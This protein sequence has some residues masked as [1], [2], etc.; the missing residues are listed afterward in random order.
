MRGVVTAA[1]A[2]AQGEEQPRLPLLSGV[3]AGGVPTGALIRPGPAL[4]RTAGQLLAARCQAAG[5]C[6]RPVPARAGPGRSAAPRPTPVLRP[7][8]R[9]ARPAVPV[10][11]PWAGCVDAGAP[12]APRPELWRPVLAVGREGQC[13]GRVGALAQPPFPVRTR[14]GRAGRLVCCPLRW[15]LRGPEAQP[16][17]A[18]ARR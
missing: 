15:A 1:P 11:P 18:S 8:A 10:L 7:T 14:Q 5:S 4:T 6:G 2:T 12:A 13:C 17:A 16:A 9:Q 3:S